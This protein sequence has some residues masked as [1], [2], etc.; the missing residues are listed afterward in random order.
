MPNC[1]PCSRNATGGSDAQQEGRR[2]IG[3]TQRTK[4]TGH[5][6][7]R[8]ILGRFTPERKAMLDALRDELREFSPAF[9]AGLFPGLDFIHP[10]LQLRFRVAPITEERCPSAD[11][12]EGAADG[13]TDINVNESLRKRKFGRGTL[14]KRMKRRYRRSHG[15]EFVGELLGF[16]DLGLIERR[17]EPGA[18]VDCIFVGQGIEITAEK[19]EK[20]RMA[21]EN[22]VHHSTRSNIGLKGQQQ[23]LERHHWIGSKTFAVHVRNGQPILCE[24]E[25][26]VGR[27]SIVSQRLRKVGS[28]P[29]S[30][31]VEAS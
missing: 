8:A 31:F 14:M 22:P 26:F 21:I 24:S 27:R 7:V 10:R 29:R 12:P 15:L 5:Q 23:L 19:V 25:A 18:P 11:M 2:P 6:S 30:E 28:N 9:S 17:Q 3:R 1:S 4:L 16:H 20:V 13:A